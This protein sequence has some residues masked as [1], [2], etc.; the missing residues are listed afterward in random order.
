MSLPKSELVLSELLS[1]QGPSSPF[2]VCQERFVRAVCCVHQSVISSR[3]L[4]RLLVSDA[5]SSGGQLSAWPV[6][7]LE[8][9]TSSEDPI[10]FG[11]CLFQ[12]CCCQTKTA[13]ASLTCHSTRPAPKQCSPSAPSKLGPKSGA[14]T[15]A[16]CWL[17]PVRRCCP[18]SR[19]R[20]ISSG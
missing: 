4:E 12:V 2:Y 13:T 8:C 1:S 18:A 6:L 17:P 20:L 9:L 14:Q 19:Q 10:S 3:A 5:D 15:L 7:I 11:F 16:P